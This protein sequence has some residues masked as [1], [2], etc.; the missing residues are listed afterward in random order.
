MPP[1]IVLRH[2]DRIYRSALAVD[3]VFGAET[4]KVFF[5]EN[6]SL[7]GDGSG[8]GTMVGETERVIQFRASTLTTLATG[9]AITVDSVVYTVRNVFPTNDGAEKVAVLVPAA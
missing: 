2:L 7:I 5:N 4:T 8:G 9:S 3:A 1:A 6:G